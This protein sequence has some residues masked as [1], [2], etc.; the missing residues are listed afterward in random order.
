MITFTELEVVLMIG[1][2][3]TVLAFMSVSKRLS[4]YKETTSM[5][6]YIIKGVA[7]KKLQVKRDSNNSIH[8]T[9]LE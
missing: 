9:E 8:I 6:D 2:F 5:M 3:I 4:I 1:W 7:D